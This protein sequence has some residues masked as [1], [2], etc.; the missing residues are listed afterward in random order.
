MTNPPGGGTRPTLRNGGGGTAAGLG[1]QEAAKSV[2]ELGAE[3]AVDDRVHGTAGQADPLRHRPRP[4][5]WPQTFNGL[6]VRLG[7]ISDSSLNVWSR[8]R[9]QNAGLDVDPE[10]IISVS[11]NLEVDISVSLSVLVCSQSQSRSA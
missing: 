10:A 4:C 9:G 6:A 2:A 5:C 8:C 11:A 7:P 1:D 3:Q